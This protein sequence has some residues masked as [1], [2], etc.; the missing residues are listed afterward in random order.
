MCT[1]LAD[2]GNLGVCVNDRWDGIV[3]DVSSSI[4]EVLGDLH[5][6]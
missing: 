4:L 1:S 2:P 5:L 6:N 3:V